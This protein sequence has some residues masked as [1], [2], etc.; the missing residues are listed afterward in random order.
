MDFIGTKEAKQRFN[1]SKATLTRW[2]RN[3]QIPNAEQD[4]PGSPWR[5]PADFTIDKL[6]RSPKKTR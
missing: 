3:G 1:V 2:C 5:I 6:V 4:A